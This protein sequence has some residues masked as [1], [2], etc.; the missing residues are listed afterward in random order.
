MATAREKLFASALCKLL[1]DLSLDQSEEWSDML[2]E[3]EDV[4]N[5]ELTT[6]IAKTGK[7]KSE[8]YS[9]TGVEYVS[10]SQADRDKATEDLGYC[11]FTASLHGETVLEVFWDPTLQYIL[12]PTDDGGFMYAANRKFPGQAF[13][14]SFLKGLADEERENPGSFAKKYY[15]QTTIIRPKKHTTEE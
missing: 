6:A 11:R 8:C 13:A 4:R 14:R 15:R 9:Y 7:P 2:Q 12:Q 10:M 1:Q 5:E 3:L